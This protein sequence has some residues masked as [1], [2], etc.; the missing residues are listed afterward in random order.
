[1]A[2]TTPN[3][4]EWSP[5]DAHPELFEDGATYLVALRVKNARTQR[6]RWEVSVITFACDGGFEVRDEHG[7]AWGWEWS[8][9]EYYVPIR[10]VTRSLDAA[11]NEHEPRVVADRL[12][13]AWDK[14]TP[15]A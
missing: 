10:D 5:R 2:T 4:F 8:D 3:P 6:T 11:I 13:A 1:M 7:D 9:V 12:R 14:D 15:H